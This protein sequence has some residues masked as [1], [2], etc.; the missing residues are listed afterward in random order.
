MT[1]IVNDIKR[2]SSLFLFFERVLQGY[3]VIAEGKKKEKKKDE[4]RLRADATEGWPRPRLRRTLASSGPIKLRTSK[5]KN[6]G[7][8]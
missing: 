7:P 3:D 6:N 5:K 8:A 1:L 4:G 2:V